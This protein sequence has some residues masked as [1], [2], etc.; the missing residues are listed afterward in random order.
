MSVF[1]DVELTWKGA[2]HTVPAN[3]VMGLICEIE[4]HITLAELLSEKGAPMGRLAKAYAAALKYAGAPATPELVYESLF[5][6]SHQN[7]PE[8]VN[9]LLSMM[10][11]PSTLQTAADGTEG[12]DTAGK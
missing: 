11:P 9:G 4:E 6:D 3:R 12:A 8:A 5:K 2:Q 7:I 10:L 1:Q